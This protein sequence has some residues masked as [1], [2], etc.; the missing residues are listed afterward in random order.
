M[1][2]S[3]RSPHCCTAEALPQLLL[4]LQRKCVEKVQ[5]GVWYVVQNN[6]M[7]VGKQC[8]VMRDFEMAPFPFSSILC[9][10]TGTSRDPAEYYL[11]ACLGNFG[12]SC[13]VFSGSQTLEQK[14]WLQ[15]AFY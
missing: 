9:R 14:I 11:C 10:K 15:V 1:F 13:I 8:S 2:T 7:N 12:Y 3:K 4:S 6:I 5:N